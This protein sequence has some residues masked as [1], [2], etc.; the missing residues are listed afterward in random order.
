MHRIFFGVLLSGLA[1]AANAA[2]GDE[3]AAQSSVGLSTTR[4]EEP[5]TSSLRL[6]RSSDLA[7]IVRT[8]G[9]PPRRSPFVGLSQLSQ[10]DEPGNKPGVARSARFQDS[11]RNG[12]VSHPPR[13]EFE[14]ER[15]KV[16]LRADSASMEG[17]NLKIARRAGSTSVFWVKSL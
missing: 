6:D 5:D 11:F 17:G 12:F 14:G 16:T 9:N 13:L 7:G 15:L 4:F 3:S 8:P 10:I 1:I 2:D